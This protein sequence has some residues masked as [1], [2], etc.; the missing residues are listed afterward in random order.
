MGREIRFALSNRF[1]LVYLDEMMVTKRSLPKSEWSQK[2]H[3]F[4]L[5]M[6]KIDT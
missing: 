3:N 4:K 2:N 5:D 6:S 1:R